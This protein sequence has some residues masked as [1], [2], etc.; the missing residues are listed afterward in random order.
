MSKQATCGRSG[1]RSRSARDRRQVVRLVQRRERARTLAGSASTPASTRSGAVVQG[2]AVHDA[3]ADADQ[4]VRAQRARAAS[5]AGARAR[6]RARARALAP[7]ASRRASRR[8][9]SLATKLRRGEQALDLAAQV[10][11]QLAA[12]L[13]E[14][15]ELE[16]DEPAFRTTIAS[17]MHSCL[18]V[19]RLARCAWPAAS[20]PRPRRAACA[21]VSARLVSTIGTRAPSTMPALS[22]PARYCS[23]LA[24]MLPASRS[25]T[26]RM[27]A[28]PAT[29]ETI[30]LIRA[31]S[32]LI[33]LSKASGPSSRPP[34]IWPRSAILHSVAASTV[35]GISGLTVSTAARIAT[36]G[37][38]MPSALREV[39]RVLHDVGLVLSVGRDVDRGVGDQQQPRIGRHVHQEH[40]ADAPRGAQAAVAT[41]PP[42][43]SARRCAGCP[44]SAPPPRRRA[45]SP[46]RASAAAWL[47]S[48]STR[49][50]RPTRSMPSASRDRADLRFGADEHRH[51]SAR[52]ARPRAARAASRGRRDGRRRSGTGGALLGALDQPAQPSVRRKITPACARSRS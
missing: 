23:C 25:G 2:A 9:A 17:A 1:A 45:P 41:A 3:V 44:S 37:C 33:A 36:L 34:V 18:R 46:P 14:Q 28:W 29:G 48:T 50:G 8:P 27:S 35:D 22:A 21:R 26:S 6:P 11:R 16:L 40:V 13:D 49:S 7:S 15:R 31:A 24:T 39:D 20:S 51:R 4:A 12:A 19:P 42:R 47:C 30:F 43:P 10:R 52:A 32:S 5:R 38:S